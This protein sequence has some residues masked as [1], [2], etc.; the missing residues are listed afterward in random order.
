MP[1]VLEDVWYT[2]PNGVDALRGVSLTIREGDFVVI[3]GPNGAGKTTLVKTFNGLIKHTRG[4]VLVDGTDT[5]QATVAELARKV[6]LVFQNPD[7]QLFCET[8]EDEIAFALRNFG[9]PEDEIR[10]R[11]DWA[12]RTF[13]LEEYRDVSPLALS[14]GEKKRVAIASVLVWEPKYLVLD[15]PTLGQDHAQKEVLRELIS[16][17]LKKASVVMVTHDIEFVVDFRPRPRVVLMA[18]GRVI[19][20]GR[21]EDVLTDPALLKQACLL[22]PQVPEVLSN[23]RDLGFEIRTNVLDLLEARDLILSLA[24][25]RR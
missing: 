4:Q 25:V 12:L 19:A 6:G 23:L 17:I 1:I 16:A 21:A 11:V 10:E 2:Y 20:D 5:R 13:G 15:E 24:G 8:V 3:M 18:G 9:F 7:H 22:R 14:G